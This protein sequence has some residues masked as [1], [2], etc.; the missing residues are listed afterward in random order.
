MVSGSMGL[1]LSR[2]EGRAAGEKEDVHEV[3][4][5]WGVIRRCVVLRLDTG[6]TAERPVLN[7]PLKGN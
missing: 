3:R 1:G 2:D 4:T 7:R 5:V 6:G